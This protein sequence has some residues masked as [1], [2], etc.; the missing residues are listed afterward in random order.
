MVGERAQDRF[1]D[2]LVFRRGLDHQVAFLHPGVIG[3]GLD[4]RHGGFHVVGRD[5]VA[6]DLAAHAVFDPAQAAFQ[7]FFAD[8]QQIYATPGKGADMRDATTHLAGAD[9]ADL[10]QS[11]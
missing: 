7:G 10:F 4:V 1:F 3:S 6:I 9:D 8:V 11:I 2:F 5:D